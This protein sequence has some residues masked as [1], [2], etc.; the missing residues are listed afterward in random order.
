MHTPAIG[1]VLVRRGAVKK[2]D[3]ERLVISDELT[4]AEAKVLLE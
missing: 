3:I 1:K 4:L 2:K